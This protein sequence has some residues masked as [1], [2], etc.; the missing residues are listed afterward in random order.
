MEPEF[1]GDDVQA[2]NEDELPDERDIDKTL[3]SGE[4]S[5]AE[6]DVNQSA[7][8]TTV[9]EGERDNSTTDI[10]TQSPSKTVKSSPK[11]RN[12]EAKTGSPSKKHTKAE[13]T[14]VSNPS[15]PTTR[16]RK[17][18]DK[19]KHRLAKMA[20]TSGSFAVSDADKTGDK[21]LLKFKRCVRNSLVQWLSPCYQFDSC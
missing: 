2:L 5:E 20:T 4:E 10:S 15:A 9:G 11:L 7:E 3:S 16:K 21:F 18:I 19:T 13:N 14:T 12:V 17:S 8:P 1:A 6:E